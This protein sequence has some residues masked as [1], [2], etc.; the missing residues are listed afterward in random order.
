MGGLGNQLFQYA[1]GVALSIKNECELKIDLSAFENQ[2]GLQNTIRNHDI[3]HFTLS[4]QIADSQEASA[5][6]NPL[7]C[8]SRASRLVR[9]K[10]FKQY[11]SDWHP[12][13]LGRRGNIYLEGYF[14]CEKYFL[15]YFS[16]LSK[17]LTLREEFSSSIAE[18]KQILSTFNKPVSL[19]VRRGDYVSDPRTSALHNIC[20]ADY[21][22]K[23]IKEM[24]SRI[25]D[26]TLVIFSDDVEWVRE[27][28][29]LGEE[30]VYVSGSK[31]QTGLPLL[32]SQELILMSRCSHHIISNST[33]SWWGAY[34]NKRHE[35]IVVAPSLWNRSR[36]DKHN[37]ILPSTWLRIET[38]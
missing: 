5:L 38:S 27:N 8:V 28:L 6:R 37:N 12:N 35:K 3:L 16:Q 19:H 33:F 9:Q 1:A 14:Q 30:A 20:T 17:E 22:H 13:I 24:R 15:N 7:G 26:F 23:A 31:A 32:P 34:L 18:W 25:S 29:S 2:H 4:A 10:I 11:Y 21:Y 36:V